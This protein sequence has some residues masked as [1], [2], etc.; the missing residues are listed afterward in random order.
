MF[1]VSDGVNRFVQP[2]RLSRFRRQVFGLEQ[3]VQRG[4]VVARLQLDFA[5]GDQHIE[6]ATDRQAFPAND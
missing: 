4:S 6:A 2:D 5:Q 3:A 1:A